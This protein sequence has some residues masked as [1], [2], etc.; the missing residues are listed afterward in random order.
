MPGRGRKPDPGSW[1]WTL[2][3]RRERRHHERELEG[4]RRYNLTVYSA[5]KIGWQ[6]LVIVQGEGSRMGGAPI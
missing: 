2:T 1:I 6:N 3:R 4:E 5:C